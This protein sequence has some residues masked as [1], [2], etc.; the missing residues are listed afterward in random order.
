M[1]SLEGQGKY[2]VDIRQYE[3]GGLLCEFCLRPARQW[4]VL[5]RADKWGN[6]SDVYSALTCTFHR[7]LDTADIG[8]GTL[9]SE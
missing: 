6:N 2:S 5:M 7:N 8:I 9:G 4:S 3:G 1:G